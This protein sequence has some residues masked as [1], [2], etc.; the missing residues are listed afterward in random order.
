MYALPIVFYYSCA[1]ILNDCVRYHAGTPMD[2]D[3]DEI[4]NGLLAVRGVKSVH[5]L[6]IWSLTLNKT[7]V[8]AHLVLGNGRWLCLELETSKLLQ[9]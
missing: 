1:L 2:V 8:A 9:I 5:N 4:R 6:G 7:A 3:F